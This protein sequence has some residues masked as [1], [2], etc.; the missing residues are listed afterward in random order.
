M[1]AIRF[2]HSEKQTKTD[3]QEIVMSDEF[4][5]GDTDPVGDCDKFEAGIHVNEWAQ[6]IVV[7]GDTAKEA[8]ILRDHLLNKLTTTVD[9]SC[10]R[11]DDFEKWAVEN[12]LS[13]VRTNVA[14]GFANG[15]R[16]AVGDYVMVESLYAWAAWQTATEKLKAEVERLNSELTKALELLGMAKFYGPSEWGNKVAAFL[17][18]Q[19]AP[20]AKVGDPKRTMGCCDGEGCTC[21]EPHIFSEIIPPFSDC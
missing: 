3:S 6:R 20:A 10:G 21:C 16:R 4:R 1:S 13:V 11:R 7:Y 14:L 12:G 8:E 15:Q 5:K 17:A 18:H 2:A 9:E 19:S